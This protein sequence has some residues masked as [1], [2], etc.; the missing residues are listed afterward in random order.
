MKIGAHVS[1]AGGIANAVERA[2]SIGS[3]CFQI[4]VTSPRTWKQSQIS[5]EQAAAFRALVQERDLAPV[6]IHAMYL[7]NLASE[8]EELLERSIDALAYTLTTAERIGVQGVMYHT[9]SRKDR[10]PAEAVAQVIGAMKE[11]LK[12]APGTSQLIVEGA[13][14]QGGAMGS[15]FEELG[16][17]VRGAGSDRVKVCLDTCHA[18]AAG[19]DIRTKDGIDRMLNEFDAAVGL[20]NLVVL[21]ANDSKFGLGEARD[22][23]E[24]I[25]EGKIGSEGF[26][27]M[28]QN[29]HLKSLPW[30]LEVPGFDD[31]GPDKKNIDR[32][33]SL[34]A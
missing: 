17:M 10:D 28:L 22:R 7:I 26:R 11:I 8:N 31:L 2:L 24:N 5:D 30:I 6:F 15:R 25:G 16:E 29:E 23:H 1:A 21:H 3:N 9:G 20:N 4:F 12:R 14:G 18:F 34:T 32:L 33:K 13:A 27:A 19:H